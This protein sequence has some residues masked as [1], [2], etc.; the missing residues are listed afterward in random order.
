VN[1]SFENKVA[2]V[3]GAGSGIGLATA[4]AFANAGASVV[5]A[6]IDQQAVQSSAE[7]LIAAGHKAI[8][9]HCDVADEAQVA[10]MVAHTVSTYGHLD[11]AFNNAGVQV[12]V[13]EAADAELADFDR[14]N[15]IN[16]RGVWTCMKHELRQMR[17]QGSGTIVNCSSQSGFVASPV[18]VLTPP[19]STQ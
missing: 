13:M 6:D 8:A 9:V 7:A 18:W 4:K 19:P 11:A 14:V 3:T 16:H 2:L 17:S 15:A 12:P 10:S 5:L 1:L